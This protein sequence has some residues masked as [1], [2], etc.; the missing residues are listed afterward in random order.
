MKE[1]E[2]GEVEAE[3]KDDKVVRRDEEVDSKEDEVEVQSEVEWRDEEKFLPVYVSSLGASLV[4]LR[5]FLRHA[6][7]LRC[8]ALAQFVIICYGL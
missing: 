8:C 7:R 1:E 4:S 2:R 3:V 6:K 5:R